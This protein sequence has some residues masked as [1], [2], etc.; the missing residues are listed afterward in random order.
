MGT[1][2]CV[3]FTY[4]YKGTH[5]N[6]CWL[7]YKTY[8]ANFKPLGGLVS[9]NMECLAAPVNRCLMTDFDFGGADI[10]RFDGVA[11]MDACVAKCKEDKHCK[12]VTYGVAGGPFDK[13]CWT[14]RA[15]FGAGGW[16]RPKAGLVSVNMAC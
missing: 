3:A 6:T 5:G 11:D 1:A 15:H 2:G 10:K 8:G 9:A 12:S 16:T 14:K 13:H 4:D 7:K